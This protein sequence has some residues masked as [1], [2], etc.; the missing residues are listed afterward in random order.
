MATSLT[1]SGSPAGF[2]IAAATVGA[3]LLA[4]AALLF[5]VIYV[6]LPQDHHFVALLLIGGLS[7]VFAFGS[8]LAQA[9][10]KDPVLQRAGTY[11]FLGMGFATLILTLVLGPTTVIGFVARLV[12][13]ILVGIVLLVVVVGIAWRQWGRE[14]DRARESARAQWRANPPPSAFEYSTA[15]TDVPPPAPSRPV[16]APPSPPTPPSGGG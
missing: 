9:I 12:G 14:S 8:Y 3:I 10:S 15:R 5:I 6:V 16:A 2:K 4:I 1:D 11:G 13:L 7:L